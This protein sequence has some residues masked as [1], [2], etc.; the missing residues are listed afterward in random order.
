MGAYLQELGPGVPERYDE[1]ASLH[2]RLVSWALRQQ[3]KQAHGDGG[4]E[5]AA[6]QQGGQQGGSVG[7]AG[8]ALQ[9]AAQREEP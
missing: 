9:A 6:E 3:N 2:N 8:D 1:F 4:A 7:T 5:P